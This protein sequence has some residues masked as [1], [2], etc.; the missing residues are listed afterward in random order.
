MSNKAIKE[1]VEQL[2][3]HLGVQKVEIAVEDED[4]F[5]RVQLD[6]AEEESGMLIGYHGETIAC[7]QR[8]ITASFFDELKEKKLLL[9]INNYKQKR[10]ETVSMLAQ[11]MADQVLQTGKAVTLPFL[12]ANERL[13]VHTT[14]KQVEGVQ[15]VSEGEG[16]QRRLVIRPS[17]E[18][19][20]PEDSKME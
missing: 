15:T 3:A 7:M 14:L 12:P 10:E 16:D 13:I 17:D 2:C 5:V 11:N 19:N 8:I 18:K 20:I 1:Y 6:V 4:Q 9:N